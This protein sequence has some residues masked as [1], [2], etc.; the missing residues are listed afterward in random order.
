MKTLA[1][2]VLLAFAVH[3]LAGC[4]PRLRCSESEGIEVCAAR[5]ACRDMNTGKFVKCPDWFVDCAGAR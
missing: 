2:F 1:A 4:A 5:P 3:L